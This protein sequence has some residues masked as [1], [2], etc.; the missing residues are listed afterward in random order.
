MSLPLIITGMH[1]SGTS[2]TAAFIQ[3]LGVNLGDNLFRGDRFNAKGYFEDLDFLEFQRRVLQDCC[4]P[5]AAG[6]PDW[7]WTEGE[8]CARAQFAAYTPKAQHLIA[9]RQQNP[10]LWGWKDPRTTLMLEFWQQLLPEARY[11]LVYRA[12]WDVADSIMRLHAPIFCQNP[13]YPVKAWHYYN[14]LL[15]EFYRQHPQQCILFN[16]NAFIQEPKRLVELLAAKLGVQLASNWQPEQFAGIYEPNLLGSLPPNHPLL[17]L[18]KTTSPQCLTLLQELDAAADIPRSEM[19]ETT[20]PPVPPEGLPVMLH[21]QSLFPR[22]QLQAL[23]AQ[24][25]AEKQQIQ[26]E[27]DSLNQE[28]ATIKTS[29]YWRLAQ[30]VSQIKQILP[31]PTPAVPHLKENSQ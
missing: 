19:P 4:P 12:P 26:A 31:S 15:L 29:K 14:R 22:E 1:R 20:A 27:I 28:I 8:T 30:A 10:S 25:A 3:A 9:S 23:A 2:L 16:I 7:G 6:W 24:A 11:L 17:H 18:M 5:G 13:H 21:Y